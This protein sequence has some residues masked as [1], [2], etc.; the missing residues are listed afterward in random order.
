MTTK[1]RLPK[2][3][4]DWLDGEI[5]QETMRLNVALPFTTISAIV[6]KCDE[7]ALDNIIRCWVGVPSNQWK[8][9]NALRNGYEAEPEQLYY[10]VMPGVTDFYSYLVK[11]PGGNYIFGDG[12][13][14]AG[15]KAKLTMPEILAIDP[16]YK[17]FTVPVEEV[18]DET[19]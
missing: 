19:N 17:E 6:R 9:I 12:E 4:V 11:R 8:L 14:I 10:V 13:E 5:K 2:K 16:R 3:V 1:E 15:Y 18:D 7:Y